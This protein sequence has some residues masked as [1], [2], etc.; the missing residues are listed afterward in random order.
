MQANICRDE[1]TALARYITQEMNA[2]A[3]GDVARRIRELNSVSAMACID[4]YIKAPF[5][6]R[7]FGAVTPDECIN[8]ELSG[9]QAALLLWTAQVMQNADW[10][11]KPKIARR[12]ISGAT[13]SR[14]WHVRDDYKYFYDIWSN[15]HYGYVGRACGFSDAMLLDGAGLEQIGS[16]LLRGHWPARTQGISSLRGFDDPSDRAGIAIGVNLQKLNPAK[17]AAEQVLQEVLSS[18]ELT[19]EKL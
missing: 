8:E 12:F 15:I 10:D 1:L 6:V 13:H 11:H 17:V 4:A 14:Y 9:K 7:L 5:L 2:N 16:D 3:H 18:T 19:R